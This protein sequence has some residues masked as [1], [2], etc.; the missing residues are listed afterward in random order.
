M[1]R[2]IFNPY[3]PSCEYIPDG[4]PHVFGD[5]IYI[6]GSHDRFGGAGF[7]L[8]DYIC[9]SADVRDLSEW[10][11]EGV[12]YRKTQD[13]RNQN[14]PEDAPEQELRHGVRPKR[15]EDLNPRGIHAMWAPDVVKG[16]DGRYYLYYCLDFISSIAV[17]V[18]GSP[19]G[20]FEYLGLVRYEDGTV[21]GERD[22]DMVQF[23]PGAFI[24]DDGTI[25]LYSGNSPRRPEDDDRMHRSQVMKLA[26]DMLTV[27]EGPYMLLPS[28][29]ESKGTGFEGHEFFEASSIRHIGNRY[30][31]IYS[32]V[33]SHELCYCTS[34]R[35]DGGYSYGGT[36]VDIGNVFL[37]GKTEE[38]TDNPLGNTH[39][40]IENIDGRWYVFYHR[41]T[42]R[43]QFSRQ[44]C[45]ERIFIEEDGSIRQAEVTSCGMNGRPLAGEGKYPAYICC[46]LTSGKGTV[47]SYPGTMRLDYPFLT[48]DEYDLDPEDIRMQQDR[49]E[50]V[51]Y[52]TNLLDSSKAVYKYF[53]LEGPSV[54][55]V[56]IRASRYRD[57][58]ELGPEAFG[59]AEGVIEISCENGGRIIGSIPVSGGKEW[60]QSSWHV[61]LPQGIYPLILTFRGTGRLDIRSFSLYREEQARPQNRFDDYMNDKTECR[62]WNSA[63]NCGKGE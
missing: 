63:C 38:E 45:A 11:Y 40:S 18:C 20:S 9:Y 30:Y 1:I 47:M 32:S 27:R 15:P 16:K 24:D 5:R 28:V 46:G 26:D 8:N 41:Q 48:Q 39:G 43:T 36:L 34:D 56:E 3:L 23:D 58:D 57:Y 2:Q 60:L 49:Y 4:E 12:I 51:Q 10:R 54:I 33:N 7:C 6:Y 62:I 61:D 13:P 35:P 31:F 59:N 53:N 14:V 21:L 52:I 29:N 37:G 25:Y 22:G 50:P 19:A 17:A 42:D 44:G 55:A